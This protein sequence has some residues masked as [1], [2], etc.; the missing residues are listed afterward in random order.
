M[1][2]GIVGVWGCVVAAHLERPV[3]AEVVRQQYLGSSMRGL[4]EPESRKVHR[5]LV[6]VRQEN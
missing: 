5:I 2:S 1:T 3:L 6:F 4:E